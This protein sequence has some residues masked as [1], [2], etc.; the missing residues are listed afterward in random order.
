MRIRATV[1]PG[2]RK[3]RFEEPEPGVFRVAVKEPAAGNAANRRV[4]E[5]LAAHFGVSISAV[6]FITG[7]RGKSKTFDVIR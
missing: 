3:E 6:R 1:T 2:A 4:R 5:L 7:M